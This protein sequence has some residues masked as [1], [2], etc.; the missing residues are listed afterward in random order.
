[1]TTTKFNR[2]AKLLT[3]LCLIS[4][5]TALLSGCQASDPFSEATDQIEVEISEQS[6]SPEKWTVN[7]GDN[8]HL[9]A[10]N[11]LDQDVIWAILQ[12]SKNFPYDQESIQ[13]A[14]WSIE[15]PPNSKIEIEFSAPAAPARYPVYCGPT[16]ELD[17]GYPARLVVVLK[18]E[19]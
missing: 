17:Q 13:Q 14:Y 12:T 19:E 18:P 15:I 5:W 9:S 4:I 3:T 7:S 6:C 11:N 16:N 1:M 10:T 8:I 2:T